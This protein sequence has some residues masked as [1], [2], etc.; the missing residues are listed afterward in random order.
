MKCWI[1]SIFNE[2]S[3]SYFWSNLEY[4]KSNGQ[5]FVIVDGGS[6]DGTREKLDSIGQKYIVLNSSTRGRRF[7][8]ALKY[9]NSE[10]IIF[11]HPRSLIPNEAIHQL[12]QLKPRQKWG[13]FTHSF[14]L[15]HPI[16]E[17]TSWWSN[18]IRG[19]L[20]GIY[21]LDH[22]LWVR[23]NILDEIN[24]FPEEA[25]FEDTIFCQR[26]VSLHHPTR[27]SSK[28]LTSS[29]RFKHNGILKQVILNQISKIKFHLGYK[30]E[31]I[32]EIYEKG[33]SL[34]RFY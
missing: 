32:D 15:K 24:G 19:D 7:N 23:K 2:A 13:A 8:E 21:Y 29:L 3:S 12:D 25:I 17:F 16:L 31:S 27:L 20:K 30:L 28:S 9:V 18:F 34:N 10:I 4:L 5:E 33:I 11:V 22:I 1:F 14:D 6:T 26:L